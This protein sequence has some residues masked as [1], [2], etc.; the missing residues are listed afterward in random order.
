MSALLR[1][2]KIGFLSIF[3]AGV[4]LTNPVN[5][6][7]EKNLLSNPGFEE[8]KN[9]DNLPDDWNRDVGGG[10]KQP[11]GTFKW[12]ST[13]KENGQYSVMVRK[14]AGKDLVARWFRY[15]LIEE[16]QE[17]Q[18]S[19]SYKTDDNF[20]GKADV[21]VHGCGVNYRSYWLSTPS[22]EWKKGQLRFSPAKSG[23]IALYLQN[24]GTGTIW[25]DNVT[26][27]E[28]P[29]QEMVNLIRNPSCEKAKP[30][31]IPA[32][33]W[34]IYP[35]DLDP[36]KAK[37]YVDT[38]KAHFGNASAKI[39]I[40]SRQSV[41]LVSPSHPV[42]PGDKLYISCFY[43][44]KLKPFILDDSA[45]KKESRLEHIRKKE[46]VVNFY[47]YHRN[48]LGHGHKPERMLGKLI[49]DGWE[50]LEGTFL[51]PAGAVHTAAQFTMS[52]VIGEA[53]FDDLVIKKLNAYSANLSPYEERVSIGKNRLEFV[54]ENYTKSKDSLNLE[55]FVDNQPAVTTTF[56]P[57]GNQ[58]EKIGIEY[59]LKGPG[60][61]KVK[62]SLSLEKDKKV[63]FAG[64]KEVIVSQVLTTS[65]IQPSYVWSG[66]NVKE[67]T[68]K[69]L[70][71]LRDADAKESVII[72]EVE[73]DGNLLKKD[74][75]TPVQPQTT[76]AF[77]VTG[78]KPGKYL[79]RISLLDKA[80]EVLSCKEEMFHLMDR[81]RPKIEVK[82]S[83]LFIEGKP[84]FPIGMFGMSRTKY[85]KEYA[86]AGF[87]FIH[88]YGF[89]GSQS[90]PA[91]SV[92][93][94]MAV[95][96]WARK[97]GV[98]CLVNTGSQEVI[99]RDWDMIRDRLLT[100]RDHPAA[101]CY[102]EEEQM[103]RGFHTPET[104][105][106]WYDLIREIDPDRP[107]LLGDTL[108]IQPRRFVPE[109]MDIGV[110]WWYPF[111]LQGKQTEVII[112]DWLVDNVA[113][114]D[115]PIWVAPQSYKGEAENKRFPTP[116][117]YRIQAYLSVIHGAKGLMYFGAHLFY[118][119]EASHWEYLKKLVSE[120]R[121]MS[122]IFLAP[123]SKSKVEVTGSD[124]I[125]TLLKEY[126]GSYYLLSA[127]RD[128]PTANVTFSLP[129]KPKKISV[130]NENREIT[131]KGEIFK[132]TFGKYAVHVYEIHN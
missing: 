9:S 54:L 90:V 51:V 42:N 44:S 111:P 83:Q 129:F 39:E 66:K 62:L 56:N 17:Y 10:K 79:M 96:D 84:F 109:L 102:M 121:D 1:A 70:V 4:V 57:S 123:T 99:K 110:W 124:K 52:E 80:G 92:R 48:A 106:K 3:C 61:Y 97:V 113:L 115:K 50:K 31:G 26:L 60:K 89:E 41:C 117:E 18:V 35:G 16:G 68:E 81:P 19:F 6:Q 76:Y 5:V 13:V 49:T 94:C 14:L 15:V 47:L 75:L 88:H 104:L 93:E 55:L 119:P 27:K 33:G 78:L 65:I 86:E 105:K 118:D 38:I 36:K 73:K 122:P 132:D 107:I 45:R 32:E 128:M 112:P 103:A 108:R 46:H 37:V 131:P 82:D 43:K 23:K 29:P 12:D 2:V 8:D 71:D 95:M 67:V 69:I 20:S 58:K 116:E 72:V 91:A 34:W 11:A 28:L 130:K 25:Y 63:L 7:A 98:W 53:W 24:S 22:T 21:M 125:S 74:R 87:N 114:T 77:P 30:D 40:Y 59:E 85:Y 120:L 101:F 126:Q 100:F 127:N 64:E